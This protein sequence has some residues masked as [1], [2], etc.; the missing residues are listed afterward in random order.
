M[1]RLVAAGDGDVV[2]AATEHEGIWSGSVDS[3][4]SQVA[5]IDWPVYALTVTA[6]GRLLAGTKGGGVLRSD[7][8]GRSWRPSS[9]GLDDAVVHTIVADGDDLLAGTGRGVARS[10]DGGA[11]W[12]PTAGALADHRIFSLLVT[13]DRRVLAGSYEGVWALGGRRSVDAARHRDERG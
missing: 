7:D 5:S 13:R 1:F 9:E 2:L 4:W 12:A 8:A 3:G 6:G 10:A 11:S